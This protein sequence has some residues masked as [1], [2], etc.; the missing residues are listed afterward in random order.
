VA[1]WGLKT[2]KKRKN[3]QQMEQL[4]S[5]KLEKSPLLTSQASAILKDDGY[6]T[7]FCVSPNDTKLNT[8]GQAQHGVWVLTR[9]YKSLVISKA[10]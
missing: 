4:S 9:P 2:P 5:Y 10:G 3:R 7:N 1:W 6:S 8:L